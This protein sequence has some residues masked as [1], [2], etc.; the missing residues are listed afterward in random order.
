VSPIGHLHDLNVVKAVGKF[1]RTLDTRDVVSVVRVVYL[2]LTWPVAP[3]TR[4]MVATLPR[5]IVDTKPLV[6]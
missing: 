5:L 4:P 2:R 3:K 6:K 1:S